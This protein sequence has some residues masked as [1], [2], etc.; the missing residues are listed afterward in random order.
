[1][2]ILLLYD[3]PS[4]IKGSFT[5]YRKIH[6]QELL[7]SLSGLVVEAI[8]QRILNTMK[9]KYLGLAQNDKILIQHLILINF[10]PIKVKLM[11]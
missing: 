2:D 8:S 7:D 3:S 1:M 10:H 4:G 5:V 6:I 11:K 9:G